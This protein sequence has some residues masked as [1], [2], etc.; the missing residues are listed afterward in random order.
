MC[1]NSSMHL[2]GWHSVNLVQN[3]PIL[4]WDDFGYCQLLGFEAVW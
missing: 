1:V 3:R 4:A 2:S